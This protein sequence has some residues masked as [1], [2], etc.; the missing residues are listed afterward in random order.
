VA[1][2][3][4]RLKLLTLAGETARGRRTSF[5]ASVVVA[6]LVCW[7]TARLVPVLRD[8]PAEVSGV[9]VTALGGILLLGFLV[10]PSALAVD[11]PLDPRRFRGLGV[12]ATRL[13]VLLAAVGTIGV[14]IVALA[15]T[16]A[17]VAAILV[18]VTAALLSRIGMALAVL[19]LAVRRRRELVGLGSL[20]IAVA[21]VAPVA[22]AL[23]SAP[24]EVA[25]VLRPIGNVLAWTPF[26]AA[27]AAPAEASFG[28]AARGF[29]RLLVAAGWVVV[30]A[31][32]WRACVAVRLAAPEEDAE[33]L[34]SPSLGWF[35]RLPATPLWAVAAR[36][37]TYWV[38]DPRYR[39]QLAVLPVVSAVVLAVL[40]VGGAET[41]Y[42]ALLP[43]PIMCLF[44]GWAPH[45]DL[46]FDNTA[47]WLHVS[48]GVRGVA[49][50][51]G[52]IVPALIVG[53]VL[54]AV[55]VPVAADAWGD[56]TARMPLAAASACL[57][58]TALGVSSLFSAAFPYP[59]VRPGGSPFTQ[60][61]ATGGSGAGA[62]AVSFTLPLI[63]SAPA[64]VLVV[65][66]FLDGT[67]FEPGIRVAILTGLATLVVG[68]A[69]GALL[70]ERRGPELLGFT[71]RT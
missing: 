17:L 47:F 56:E 64:V 13:T 42:L 19:A 37:M 3:I 5:A 23:S 39:V 44:L 14:P 29:G 2:H 16:T 25:A 67:S 58:L 31:A 46:S 35:G 50:R 51:V 6:V 32:L 10:V 15:T 26:G 69:A 48:S 1:G 38:R 18:V 7:G 30:L 27:W 12:G 71:Q 55:G 36:T 52:R 4:L 49:D 8:A 65:R 34:T 59:A 61:Q 53:A 11:D 60:P 21:L 66:A 40:V 63:L 43:L 45:N 33:R 68:V 57:L 70:V 9:L 41:R 54:L 62:Q 24:D 20:A 28:G 22:L